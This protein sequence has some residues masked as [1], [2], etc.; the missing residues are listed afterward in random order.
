M[1]S[2][3]VIL[4]SLSV[5]VGILGSIFILLAISVDSWEEINFSMTSTNTSSLTITPA[6]SRSDVTV[7]HNINT[8]T[9]SFMYYQYGGP[10]K[11]CDLLTDDARA[12][13]TTL[14][15]EYRDRCYNFV[16]EYDEESSTLQSDG[17]SIA[18]LQNSGAS[19]FI[20]CIIDL[21]AALG[22]GVIALIHKHVTACMVTGVLYCMASLFTVF[23]LAIFHVKHHYELYYCQSL[24]PIPKDSCEYRTLTILWAVPVAWVG[25][26][27]CC[28]ASVLWLFL[29]RAL[30]VIKAKTMI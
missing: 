14:G 29:T 9:Y 7:Y 15:G 25:V 24:Y 18:R 26:V 13:I 22:V 10:W 6:T 28:A 21:V 20:V 16:S 1:P 27:V 11:L 17:K 5:V 12:K 19:C 30:R 23:G 8:D 4:A 2:P 3:L